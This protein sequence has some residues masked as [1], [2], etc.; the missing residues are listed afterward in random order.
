MRLTKVRII[1]VE[2]RFKEFLESNPHI[3][4]EAYGGIEAFKKYLLED[5]EIRQIGDNL[6]ETIEVND[7]YADGENFSVATT[8][9]E[10]EEK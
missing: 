1:D 4:K 8:K 6:C 5:K 9:I 2:E 7:M 3:D 10:K